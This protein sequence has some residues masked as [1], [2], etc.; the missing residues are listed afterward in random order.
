MPSDEVVAS[1]LPPFDSNPTRKFE[2]GAGWS[3]GCAAAV[4]ADHERLP[5][6]A[7]RQERAARGL[8]GTALVPRVGRLARNPEHAP[9]GTFVAVPPNVEVRR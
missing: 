1:A 8:P 7:G 4:I 3:A 6:T 5:G 9:T 2:P